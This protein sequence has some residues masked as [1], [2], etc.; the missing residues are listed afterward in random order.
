ME[1]RHLRPYFCL[2]DRESSIDL[3]VEMY[4]SAEAF[5]PA[6]RK[7]DSRDL[8][9]RI[10]ASYSL[11]SVAE[12]ALRASVLATAMIVSRAADDIWALFASEPSEPEEEHAINVASTVNIMSIFVC[13]MMD[14]GGL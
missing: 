13:I 2:A 14:F 8:I 5:S 6:E 10:S 7:S 1:I 4:R 3:A 12:A 11:S 9:S